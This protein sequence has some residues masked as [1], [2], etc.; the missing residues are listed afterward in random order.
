[1][2]PDNRT[3]TRTLILGIGIDDVT[4]DEAI[5]MADR[6]IQEHRPFQ[7]VT[8]N[9]EFIMQARRDPVFRETMEQAQLVTPDGVG[10]IYA[11][12]IL[13]HPFRGRVPGVEFSH[14]LAA[15]AAA[16]GYRLYLLGAAPGV[17]EEAGR[18]L[19]A[20]YPGLIIAGTYPGSP[21]PEEEEE[22][23]ARVR[24]AAP[25]ILLVAYGAPRQD[26]WLHRN[27]PHLDPLVGVGVGG[28]LDYIA[29]HVRRA[30]AWMR[31]LGLEWFYRLIRQPSRWK[32]ML[33]L[34]VF[35]FRVFLE[36]IGGKKG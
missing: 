16:R 14:R 35:G 26:I 24:A 15:L 2:H 9:P 10:L 23:R 7:V 6:S 8:A 30:P 18:K 31:R 25:H 12:R 34:P 20:E 13:R 28:T 32:R 3:P 21:A 29:G 1:M 36:A 5:A 33:A 19:Q 4:E 11:G 27:M 22:I 17:A